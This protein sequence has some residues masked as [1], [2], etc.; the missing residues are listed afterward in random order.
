[1][2]GSVRNWRSIAYVPSFG[3]CCA[4]PGTGTGAVKSLSSKA[5][6]WHELLF[7]LESLRLIAVAD[8]MSVEESEILGSLEL[9]V[10]GIEIQ[11]QVPGRR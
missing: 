3:Q 1:L 7:V 6:P 10:L 5:G 11:T 4:A 8:R 2:N 9:R